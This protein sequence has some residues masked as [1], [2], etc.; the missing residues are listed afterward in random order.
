MEEQERE[1]TPSDQRILKEMRRNDLRSIRR[2]KPYVLRREFFADCL[3][4][5]LFIYALAS[6]TFLSIPKWIVGWSP[7]IVVLTTGFIFC[8]INLN[9]D[10]RN[11][12]VDWFDCLFDRERHP[13]RL[14]K[15]EIRK[16]AREYIRSDN[17]EKKWSNNI[18]GI[19]VSKSEFFQEHRRE[20]DKLEYLS[21]VKWYSRV[22]GLREQILFLHMFLA[23]F[24][25]WALG[26]LHNRPDV[27]SLPP[28]IF[29]WVP[30]VTLTLWVTFVCQFACKD[31]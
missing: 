4:V 19:P 9:E 30:I 10:L 17:H 18:D 25:L 8:R 13:D 31:S 28:S 3:A 2:S 16:F 21:W 23:L 29:D 11:K 6:M 5:L 7:S 26:D 20:S 15:K 12:I 22:D 1:L 14:S 24:S 27:D